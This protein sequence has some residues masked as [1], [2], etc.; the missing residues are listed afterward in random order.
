MRARLSKGTL[1]ELGLCDTPVAAGS[2]MLKDTGYKPGSQYEFDVEYLADE[3]E[4]ERI[5]GVQLIAETLRTVSDKSVTL[6]LL[7]GMTD[8]WKLLDEYRSLVSQKVA[9]V[10]LMGGVEVEGEKDKEVV[11]LDENGY[12]V[13]DKAQNNTFD[14]EAAQSLY[15][16]LQQEGIQM[17]VVTRWAAYAAKL[18]LSIYDRMAKTCSPVG[19]RLQKAQRFS[20]EHLWTRACMP[21]N[22]EKREGLPGRCDKAWFS[23]VFLAGK[24][25]DRTGDDSIWDLT[26]T[27]QAYDPL[28]QMCAVRSLR[29]KFFDPH[30]VQ[31]KATTGDVIFHEVVGLSESNHQVKNGTGLAKFLTNAFLTGLAMTDGD[32]MTQPVM[33]MSDDGK[34]LDDELAKVLMTSLERRDLVKCHGY[35]ANLAPARMR[36]KLAKGT[37]DTLGMDA[38]VFIG[39]EMIT[40]KES[41]YEFEVPYL[42]DEAKV[43][44]G[45]R[46][47]DGFAN[48]LRERGASAAKE[49]GFIT[50]VCLSGLTDAWTLF[51]EYKDLFKE[52][53]GRVVIMGGVEVDEESSV[54]RDEKGLMIPDKAQNN[55][56]DMEAAQNLY[57]ELQ[58]EGIP[59]TVVTRFAA[60]AA[61]LPLTLYDEMAG[62]GHPVGL[63]MHGGLEWNPILGSAD[64][65]I[66]FD[67]SFLG[68]LFGRLRGCFRL[69]VRHRLAFCRRIRLRGCF[70]HPPLFRRGI[71]RCSGDVRSRGLG[72]VLCGDGMC[73]R[74]LRSGRDSLLDANLRTALAGG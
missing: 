65:D 37:L 51:H 57:R 11:K 26:G 63:R 15:R 36:A 19:I 41:P 27:F 42:A 9:R 70:R 40:P 44:P 73:H 33:V 29:K 10:V 49:D 71:F 55:A 23:K 28:A 60:Y 4:V 39:S 31:I 67:V 58:L 6:V 52:T 20:L 69:F 34:D 72:C 74:L 32:A 22:D 1:V 3:S 17:T 47:V 12:M 48:I 64:R 5:S 61:K 18:P 56:F 25:M 38:P 8:A 59:L 21:E 16:G 53:I 68:R 7:S 46:G 13:P 35:I 66:F 50:L 45:T 30:Q 24:G 54:K 14:F 2:E 62:T 43:N